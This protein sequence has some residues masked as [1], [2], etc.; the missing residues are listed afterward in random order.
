MLEECWL[1]NRP[2]GFV[3]NE[4]INSRKDQQWIKP[5]T[6]RWQGTWQGRPWSP[7]SWT[8]WWQRQ[9]VPLPLWGHVT[10]IESPSRNSKIG[11]HM[12]LSMSSWA[13][14]L[15]LKTT[16]GK[17][18]WYYVRTCSFLRYISWVW[19]HTAVIPAIGRLRQED[20]IFE[21]MLDCIASSKP[22]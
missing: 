4:S 1:E 20:D 5:L 10:D 9:W 12:N 21:V 2:L 15:N 7:K 16:N 13:P 3:P 17:F 6:G 19:R 8:H 14:I 22:A 18:L 11:F